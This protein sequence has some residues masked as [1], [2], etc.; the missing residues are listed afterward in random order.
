MTRTDHAIRRRT[1]LGAIEAVEQLLGRSTPDAERLGGEGLAHLAQA[2]E[3]LG[4]DCARAACELRLAA[5]AVIAAAACRAL[6]GATGLLAD[7]HVASEREERAACYLRR[8]HRL[9]SEQLKPSE[10]GE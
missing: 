5:R 10:E 6:A 3:A 9:V 1:L 8:A 7:V 4:P 2:V